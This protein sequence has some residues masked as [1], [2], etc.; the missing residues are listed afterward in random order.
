MNS[1][2]DQK[3]QP[4][5]PPLK[6]FRNTSI[7]LLD[8]KKREMFKAM[9][10]VS[11]L[12]AETLRV[13]DDG[14]YCTKIIDNLNS[15]AVNESIHSQSPTGSSSASIPH[16]APVS[17]V[18]SSSAPVLH[19][20][21]SS[22]PVSHVQSSSAPASHIQSSSAPASHVQSSSAPVSDVQSSSAPA[23]HVQS[24]SAPV[25]HVQSSSA[26]V[27]DHVQSSTAP[28]SHVQ[29]SSAPVSD[30]Q[31]TS[32]PVSHVQSSSVPASY[33]P[34]PEGGDS[35]IPHGFRPAGKYAS[36]CSSAVLSSRGWPYTVWGPNPFLR[37][38]TCAMSNYRAYTAIPNKVP[39]ER[40]RCTH[41]G[42]F[43]LA[44]AAIPFPK[45]QK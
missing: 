5:G 11:K 4:E 29:S 28:A 37:L 13:Y 19:V 30:V 6:H 34:V 17:H 31:S 35:S 14:G 1:L 45:R 42:T 39:V 12:P 9:I 24:S 8:V 3:S 18:Q 10:E 44:L 43:S 7:E 38:L 22:A 41:E 2:M 23:S 32:A 21:C 25:S 26:Q 33:S 36:A 40:L 15:P 20:Q 27:S 16:S